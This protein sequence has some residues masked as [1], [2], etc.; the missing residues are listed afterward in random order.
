MPII[1]RAD[2]DAI[3]E[4]MIVMALDIVYRFKRRIGKVIDCAA[5]PRLDP[6]E[7]TTCLNESGLARVKDI[8]LQ[9]VPIMIVED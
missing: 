7:M 6:F 5:N 3:P 4:G 9:R 1:D 8:P 2:V